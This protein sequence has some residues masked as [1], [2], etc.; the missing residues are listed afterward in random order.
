MRDRSR[1]SDGVTAA[2]IVAPPADIIAV[3]GLAK[4]YGTR[5]APVVALQDIDFAIA[6]G[7]FVA[8]VGPSGCGKST[9][10]RILAGILPT[11][12][13]EVLLRGSRIAGPRRDIGVVFQAPVLFPWRTVLDNVLLPIDVQKL[14]RAGHR[15][16]AIELLALVGLAGF[17]QRYPWELSCGMQQRVAIV[18]ALVHD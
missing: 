11:T 8:I 15:Q 17:E 9:L 1:R 14:G 5:A 4:H 16:A 7:A 10:L 6:D 12:H 2:I 13:G 3:R 18:R